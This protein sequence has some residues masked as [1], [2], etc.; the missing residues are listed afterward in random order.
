MY[1]DKISDGI[2]EY[3][4]GK[5][6]LANPGRFISFWFKHFVKR[7]VTFFNAWLLTSYEMWYPGAIFDCY[8]GGQYEEICYFGY[9]TE[10]PGWRNLAVSYIDKVYRAI[11]VRAWPHKIPVIRFIWSPGTWLWL[12]AA[13]M[14]IINSRGKRNFTRAFIFLF[15]VYL[16]MLLGPA[17]LVRYVAYI[18]FVAPLVVSGLL[19]TDS[20]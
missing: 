6:I 2:K 18:F 14:T 8:S 12:S 13:A 9:V 3:V 10:E 19:F 11:S 16:T 7:P 1:S 4:D 5:E 15:I 17:S 20:M